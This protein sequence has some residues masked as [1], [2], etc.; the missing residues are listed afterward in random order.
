MH[1]ERR[2]EFYSLIGVIILWFLLLL[3]IVMTI[4]VNVTHDND[5]LIM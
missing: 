3:E 4:L 2:K 5:D 1:I